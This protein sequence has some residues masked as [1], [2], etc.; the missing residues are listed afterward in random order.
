MFLGFNFIRHRMQKDM[1]S[2]IILLSMLCLVLSLLIRNSL[3]L[4]PRAIVLLKMQ[5]FL[6]QFSAPSF[7][8]GEFD[9]TD[10]S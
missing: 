6:S 7:G 1:I 9:M 2:V 8:H 5:S 3:R 10:V 4:P